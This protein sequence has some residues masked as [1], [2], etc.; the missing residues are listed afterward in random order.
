MCANPV[1]SA[2]ASVTK[3]IHCFPMSMLCMTLWQMPALLRVSMLTDMLCVSMG[4][5]RAWGANT[6]AA[7]YNFDHPSAFDEEAIIYTLQELK[8]GWESRE[9]EVRLCKGVQGKLKLA[10]GWGGGVLREEGKIGTGRGAE[11]GGGT[12]FAGDCQGG[13]QRELRAK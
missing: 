2:F 10:T 12:C 3:D 6:H 8:V 9:G 1:D 11:S 4:Q 7:E 13:G 5:Q